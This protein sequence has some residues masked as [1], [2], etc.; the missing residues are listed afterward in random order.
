MLG[1]LLYE[2]LGPDGDLE[3]VQRQKPP[4]ATATAT[5]VPIG[6]AKLWEKELIVKGL[7][8]IGLLGLVVVS[9]LMMPH[10]EGRHR[11]ARFHAWLTAKWSGQSQEPTSPAQSQISNDALSPELVAALS[12]EI[13]GKSRP[14]SRTRAMSH[15]NIVH[16]F[17]VNVP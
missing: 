6:F 11:L 8:G 14:L 5:V 17:N 3:N 13:L 12:P 2:V 10:L 15:T 1:A 9:F 7:L 16:T 4:I